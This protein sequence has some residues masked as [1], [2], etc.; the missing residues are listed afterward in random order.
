M[1]RSSNKEP[2]SKPS[3]DVGWNFATPT[4]KKGELLCN[5]YHKKITGGITRLKQHLAHRVKL[6]LA[7]KF[8]KR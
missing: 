1:P 4:G 7:N 2:G 6:N 8:H 3:S 5:F